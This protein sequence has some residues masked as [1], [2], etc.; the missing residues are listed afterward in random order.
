MKTKPHSTNNAIHVHPYD[1]HSYALRHLL[2][3]NE[4][5]E[6]RNSKRREVTLPQGAP[7][8]PLVLQDLRQSV[9]VLTQASA[10][11]LG[12]RGVLGVQSVCDSWERVRSVSFPFSRR[13]AEMT[14]KER[15]TSTVSRRR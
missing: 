11:E 7:P 10:F 9:D 6:N 2:M 14:D 5:R 1:L 4:N 12:P 3:R 15:K 8:F 13:H